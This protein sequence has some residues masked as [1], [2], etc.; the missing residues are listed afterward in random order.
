MK[1]SLNLERTDKQKCIENLGDKI[2]SESSSKEEALE[3]AYN[4]FNNLDKL[5]KDINDHY[6]SLVKLYLLDN[7]KDMCSEDFR[8]Y[9]AGE[10]FVIGETDIIFNDIREKLYNYIEGVEDE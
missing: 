7:F 1:T 3:I 4:I 2:L 5:D 8:D 10:L 6:D 9:K